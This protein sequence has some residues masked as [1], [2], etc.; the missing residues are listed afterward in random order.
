MTHYL[1]STRLNHLYTHALRTVYIKCIYYVTHVER[2]LMISLKGYNIQV[3]NSGVC[4]FVQMIAAK[5]I[6]M[7]LNANL[8]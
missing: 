7:H 6:L 1:Y 5:I 2:S 4:Y 3:P 8:K